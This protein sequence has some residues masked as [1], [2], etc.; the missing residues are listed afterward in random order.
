MAQTESNEYAPSPYDV[1]FCWR[2]AVFAMLSVERY[3]G[4]ADAKGVI[5]QCISQEGDGRVCGFRVFGTIFA[6]FLACSAGFLVGSIAGR[7]PYD[8]RFNWRATAFA[9]LLYGKYF[10]GADEENIINQCISQ[11]GED[12]KCGMH[13][14]NIGLA[15]Y[16]TCSAGYVF[17]FL[18]APFARDQGVKLSWSVTIFAV[19]SY[20][21][22]VGLV[23]DVVDVIIQCIS[24]EGDGRE[25]GGQ[26]IETVSTLLLTYF[27]PLIVG[28]LPRYPNFSIPSDNEAFG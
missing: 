2:A 16:L 15:L 21:L 8:V 6:L 12:G 7:I 17:T 25:C 23:D 14:I 13:I 5:D 1:K 22:Y 20:V 3:I 19:L 27:V 18:V 4:V 10:G 9:V 26:V 11:E 28:D 24:R